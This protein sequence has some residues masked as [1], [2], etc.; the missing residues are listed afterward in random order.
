MGNCCK[1]SQRAQSRFQ[2]G[3]CD[4]DHL[5]TLVRSVQLCGFHDIHRDTFHKELAH[6]NAIGICQA[7][8]DVYPEGIQ[9]MQVS[10]Q[11]VGRDD[12]S[13]Q[14][15]GRDEKYHDT[16]FKG[17]ISDCQNVTDRNRQNQCGAD[18]HCRSHDR[19]AHAEKEVLILKQVFISG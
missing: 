8:N 10:V 6:Q 11:N 5:L 1:Q 7:R 16:V 9:K 15:H 14:Y 13:A 19:D 4:M 12:S 17:K 3:D 18:T 2:K